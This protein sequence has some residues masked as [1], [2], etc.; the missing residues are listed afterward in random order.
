MTGASGIADAMD[1]IELLAY[2]GFRRRSAQAGSDRCG[3]RNEPA[4]GKRSGSEG[5]D[6]GGSGSSTGFPSR[7]AHHSRRRRARRVAGSSSR[8]RDAR[9]PSR[10]DGLRWQLQNARFEDAERER[11]RY[12][13]ATRAMSELVIARCEY[14]K[15]K[16]STED[17]LD[18]SAWSPF[19]NVLTAIGRQTVMQPTPAP[20]ATCY[21]SHATRNR[22]RHRCRD[23]SRSAS[24]RSIDHTAD[25]YRVGTGA[26]RESLVRMICRATTD[27]ERPGDA[28]FIG[29]SRVLD[30]DGQVNRSVPSLQ[31][32]R[33]MKN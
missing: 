15:L 31:P 32:S 7:S 5:S 28:Q 6:P 19:G 2:P 16:T 3:S 1:R 18:T 13:A 23:G 11:L 33:P 24:K 4:Q 26:T 14:P 30:A 8:S 12:V 17:R 22:R 27:G 25:G 20:G 9:L 29:A 10:P 21:G